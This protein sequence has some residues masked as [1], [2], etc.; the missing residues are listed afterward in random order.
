[1]WLMVGWFTL[2]CW[3]GKDGTGTGLFQ[4]WMVFQRSPGAPKTTLAL[5]TTAGAT[6]FLIL[7]LIVR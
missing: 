7:L 6:A 2:L 4:P 3:L 5:A 1:M